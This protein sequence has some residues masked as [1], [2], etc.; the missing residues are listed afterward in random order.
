MKNK[1]INILVVDDHQMNSDAYINLIK[2]S[3]GKKEIIFQK[4]IDCYSA[5]K[6][7]RQAEKT[8][9]PI[10]IALIDISIPEYK[11]EKLLSG[12]DVAL[13]LRN[14]FPDCLI[15]MLTMHTEPL[16]LFNVFKQVNPEGF[17]SK[18]D[19]DFEMFPEVF[20]RIVNIENYFSPTINT[21][22]QSLVMQTLKWDEFDTQIII[23][24][25][26]G[27][28]TKDLTQYIDLSLSS[29]EKRKAILK[30]QIL[31]QKASDKLLIERCKMLKLI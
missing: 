3:Q 31:D 23:L 1:K 8:I 7:I 21:A 20:D 4:A 13:L 11:E 19:I 24:L 6:V 22:I 14:S 17:I 10:D 12:T 9:T 18:N 26:K 25:E 30:R 2:S 5:L 15:I 28:Q 27:I 29:I 16:I